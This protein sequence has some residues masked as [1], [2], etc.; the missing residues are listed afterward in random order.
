M[1]ERPIEVAL[2][3]EANLLSDLCQTAVRVA[4][5]G[6]RALE[7]QPYDPG[8]WSHAD[9][10]L[11]ELEE[12]EAFKVAKGGKLLEGDFFGQMDIAI[13]FDSLPLYGCKCAFDKLRLDHA[14]LCK[15]AA[16]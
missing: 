7:P 15:Q 4:Q 1:P 3:V 5:Q 10:L 8:V 16:K 2:I 13:L 11:E 9:R 12:M 14:R 6:A